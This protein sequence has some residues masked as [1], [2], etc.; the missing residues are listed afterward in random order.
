[1]I[2]F[3]YNEEEGFTAEEN[4]LPE[5][6]NVKQIGTP[7]TYKKIY[8][9]DFVHTYLWQYCSEGE[10]KTQLAVL[11]GNSVR[12]GGCRHIYIKSAFPVKEVTEKQGRYE[13]SEKAWGM[14]YQECEK[15]FP[16]QEIL[17][18]FLARPG[19]V[20]EKNSI[21]EATHCTYFSGADKVL[22]MMEPVEG[23]SAFFGFDG[24]RFE[25]QSGYYIY[26][27][28]NEP[29][30]EF[31]MEKKGRI[32][33]RPS[34]EMPDVAMANFRKILKEK[35]SK[36]EQRKKQAMSYGK[37]AAV[38][39]ALFV[40][41]AALKNRTEELVK[42]QTQDNGLQQRAEAAS[43]DVIVEELP[44]EVKTDEEIPVT[45]MQAAEPLEELPAQE[46]EEPLTEGEEDFL[47]EA[48]QETEEETAEEEAAEETFTEDAAYTAYTVQ[49]GDTLASICRTYYGTDEK[50]SEV[51]KLNEIAD[52]D[53]IQAG[54]IILLP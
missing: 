32:Q 19:F 53:Y 1:M 42:M 29:M 2:E 23:E 41:A 20:V 25:K 5:P 44:G 28:K 13:F 30:R 18:W 34:G 33:K 15:Y 47:E 22:L 6:K 8:L 51:C 40:G 12:S 24:N 43:S 35:Q 50:I 38:V 11:L 37:K 21:V 52:G 27:E 46:Q 36:K 54:E 39:M 9:E 7:K 10:Q 14:I 3:I 48:A 17:G 4:A 26:Y 16:D 49:A 45:E 31:M